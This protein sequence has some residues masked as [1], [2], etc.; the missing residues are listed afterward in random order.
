PFHR[1]WIRCWPNSREAVPEAHALI[2]AFVDVNVITV[3]ENVL[4]VGLLSGN[5]AGTVNRR[6]IRRSLGADSLRGRDDLAG[7]IALR[8]SACG[9]QENTETHRYCV[10]AHHHR[11]PS[12]HDR[13]GRA[14]TCTFE[15]NKRRRLPQQNGW[16]R[17]TL[18]QRRAT[19]PIF[20]GLG[21]VNADETVWKRG[22]AHLRSGRGRN[23]Q[24]IEGPAEASAPLHPDSGTSSRLAAER[25]GT[26]KVFEL[27]EGFPPKGR[28]FG[29]D[30]PAAH[31]RGRVRWRCRRGIVLAHE[32]GAS[33]LPV[34]RSG[35]GNA[36]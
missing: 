21:V 7:R 20:K 23:G 24:G 14:G 26:P 34:V 33:G 4:D 9:R 31:W 29:G 36:A 30:L 3:G 2:G 16:G 32:G 1:Q 18:L 10:C 5:Q 12:T 15:A 17:F 35:S 28:R 25:P 22:W 8:R 13:K 11:T 6:E 27:A 19:S